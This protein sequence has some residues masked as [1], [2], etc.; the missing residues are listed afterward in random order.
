MNGVDEV[1]VFLD[2]KFGDAG[3]TALL[4]VRC[5][6]DWFTLHRRYTSRLELRIS[7]YSICSA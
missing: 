5:G 4:A 1:D 6:D 2:T 7:R 3:F